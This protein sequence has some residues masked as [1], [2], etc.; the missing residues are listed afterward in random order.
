MAIAIFEIHGAG[1]FDLTHTVEHHGAI[2]RV[3]VG[4]PFLQ[5][6][7]S[8]GLRR[9][10]TKYLLQ[11]RG[12]FRLAAG[13]VPDKSAY[14]GRGKRHNPAVVTDLELLLDALAGGDIHIRADPFAHAA[15]R[16]AHRNA[17][18]LEIAPIAVARAHAE[19]AVEFGARGYRFLPDLLHASAIA[20]MREIQPVAPLGLFAFPPRQPLPIFGNPNIVPRR[21][22]APHSL[23]CGRGQGAIA[24]LAFAK[25]LLEFGFPLENS[26]GIRRG[27]GGNPGNDGRV[28]KRLSALSRFHS[29][30]QIVRN[31][32]LDH[33]PAGAGIKRL[34]HHLLRIV[35][36]EN[37]DLRAG[38]AS[39]D[40]ARRFQTIQ[41]WHADVH[42]DEV[43]TEFVS[44][45]DGVLPVHGFA[46][47]FAVPLGSQ[48]GADAPPDHF[49][50]VGD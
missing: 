16:V 4:E 45:I 28:K 11:F 50:I 39:A 32:G 8:R 23:V 7:A 27:L 26:L 49:V 33:K 20:G 30:Q 10:K 38:E 37:Q 46:A 47:D 36:G 35:L 13:R 18:R 12:Q 15:I 2:V 44:L 17:A 9:L 40:H 22:A 41:V 14:M 1:G 21:I 5:M 19:L 43:G 34:A 24:L 3:D 42:D 48:Q 31:R 25:R 6:R 29:V